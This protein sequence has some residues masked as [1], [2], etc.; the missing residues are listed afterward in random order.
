[1]AETDIHGVWIGENATVVVTSKLVIAFLRPHPGRIISVLKQENQGVI[2]VVDGFALGRSSRCEIGFKDKA[3]HARIDLHTRDGVDCDG[4]TLVYE[5][6]DGTT[7]QCAL[8]EKIEILGEMWPADHHEHLSVAEK[9]ELWNLG[10]Y[11]QLQDNTVAAGVNTRRYI[12]DPG[13]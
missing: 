12:V 3:N 4:E 9:L 6:H 5:T 8:A 1:M 10:A 11:F 7:F 2:G 13:N